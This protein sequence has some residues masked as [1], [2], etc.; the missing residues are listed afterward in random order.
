MA[1]IIFKLYIS[2]IINEGFII[3]ILFLFFEFDQ[4]QSVGYMGC[5]N[6]VIFF[7]MFLS[8]ANTKRQLKDLLAVD[9]VLISVLLPFQVLGRIIGST[10]NLYSP[11]IVTF[12]A[13]IILLGFLIFRLFGRSAKMWKDEKEFMERRNSG[14]YISMNIIRSSTVK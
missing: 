8:K 11:Y 5:I 13:V 9:Y 7:L 10:I 3:L 12:S 1:L 14:T 4:T 2:E 6:F